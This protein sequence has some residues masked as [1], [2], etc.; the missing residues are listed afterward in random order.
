MV[1]LDLELVRR[2][3]RHPGWDHRQALSDIDDLIVEVERLRE[4]RRKMAFRCVA[5]EGD[6]APGFCV[7]CLAVALRVTLMGERNTK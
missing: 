2:R 4:E 7:C 3:W 1:E 5:H 6:E